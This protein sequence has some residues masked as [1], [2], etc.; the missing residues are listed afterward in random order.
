[1]SD[2][3]KRFE[4]LGIIPVVAINDAKHAVPL[5][6]ALAAGGLPMAEITFRTAA[7]EE[8]IRRISAEVPEV[9]CGAGTVLTIEQCERAKKAGAKYIVAPG[10]G[11]KVVKWCVENEMPVTPGV[12]TPSDITAALEY[13]LEVLKFFPA[14]NS[15][16]IAALKAMAAPFGGVRFIPTGGITAAN[17]MDYLS[18]PK[19][20]ACG[21]SWMVK[22]EMIAAEQFDAITKLTRDAVTAMLGFDLAHVGFNTA[23]DAES[24]SATKRLDAL[25]SFGVKEGNSSNFAGKIV[26]VMKGKGPGAKGHIA[27]YTNSITRAMAY[28]GRMGVAFDVENAKPAGGP[29]KAM[30]LKEEIAGYAVHLLQR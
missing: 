20:V 12:C 4:E 28:L 2:M 23:D 25:F 17:L 19:V 22:S 29:Y 5:A 27:I 7:A 18:F 9:L 30:Y 8:S 15:G 21:G 6:K 26:E 14:E 16:G 11:E 3:F 13:G 10:L 1:M 24:L